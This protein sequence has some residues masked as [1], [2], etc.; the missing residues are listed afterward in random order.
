ML[1]GYPR[2]EVFLRDDAEKVKEQYHLEEKH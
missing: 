2:N 1:C